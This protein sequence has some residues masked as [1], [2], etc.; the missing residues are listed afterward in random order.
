MIK[1]A[2]VLWNLFRIK[3]NY[4][5]ELVVDVIK[6]LPQLGR[7]PVSRI[8]VTVVNQPQQGNKRERRGSGCWGR[9]VGST[10][11]ALSIDTFILPPNESLR[12]FVIRLRQNDLL[13]SGRHVELDSVFVISA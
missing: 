10:A 9:G 4:C 7:G 6:L 2:G 5:I 3:K 11:T 12:V 1:G 8:K 13:M